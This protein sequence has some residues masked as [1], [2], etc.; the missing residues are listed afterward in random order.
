MKNTFLL[1]L[2]FVISNNLAITKDVN[3]VLNEHFLESHAKRP[4]LLSQT[5]DGKKILKLSQL[6][7][8]WVESNAF[9]KYSNVKHLDLSKN[10][11]R[12][13]NYSFAQLED[14]LEQLY[15]DKV[16]NV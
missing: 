13:L 11:I 2:S 8:A 5:L 4:L 6:R 10:E 7:I 9:I 14:S 3:I 15:L 1:I 16:L 12:V